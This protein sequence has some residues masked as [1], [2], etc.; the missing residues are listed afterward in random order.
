MRWRGGETAELRRCCCCLASLTET[1]SNV[2]FLQTVREEV[3]TFFRFFDRA[4]FLIKTDVR[5]AFEHPYRNAQYHYRARQTV[6][7]LVF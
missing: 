2:F 7:L 4:I 1:C 5:M 6:I 3:A